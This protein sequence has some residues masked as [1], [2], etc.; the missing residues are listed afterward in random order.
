[1]MLCRLETLLF[2]A[3]VDKDKY[4]D[5]FTSYDGD[6]KAENLVMQLHVLH[7]NLPAEVQNE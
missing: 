3:E 5:V 2:T 1:M 6:L 4:A 7:S